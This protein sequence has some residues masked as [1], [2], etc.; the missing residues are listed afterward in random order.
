MK[1]EKA[2]FISRHP[3]FIF[4]AVFNALMCGLQNKKTVSM[5]NIHF[6]VKYI[7]VNKCTAALSQQMYFSFDFDHFFI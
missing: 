6:Y 2:L 7:S 4:A 5:S 1:S 3:K